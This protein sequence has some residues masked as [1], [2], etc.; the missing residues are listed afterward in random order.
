MVN[1]NQNEKLYRQLNSQSH[2]ILL[3][4]VKTFLKE[5]NG[6]NFQEHVS[7]T[8]CISVSITNSIGIIPLNPHHDSDLR[9]TIITMFPCGKTDQRP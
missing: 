8:Y 6:N 9:V 7:S 1:I 3:S 5:K 4:Y 2:K